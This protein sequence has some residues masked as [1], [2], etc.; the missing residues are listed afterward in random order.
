M[1]VEVAGMGCLFNESNNSGSKSMRSLKMSVIVIPSGCWMCFFGE[2][3]SL[4]RV[5]IFLE[6]DP[7]FFGSSL[8]AVF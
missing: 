4:N 3:L 1:T 7:L 8:F 2:E 6:G 5:N